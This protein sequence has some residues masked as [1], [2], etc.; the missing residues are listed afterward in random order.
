LDGYCLLAAS[1]LNELLDDLQIHSDLLRKIVTALAVLALVSGGITFLYKLAEGILARLKARQGDGQRRLRRRGAFAVFV[2][3]RVRDLDNKEEW[4]D[5]RFAELEAEVE[6]VGSSGRGRLPRPSRRGLR[7]ERSLSRA[8]IQGKEQLVLL[9]GDPGSGKSVALRFVAR[10]MAARATKSKRLDAVIPLY[11]NLK[12]LQPGGRPIDAQLIEEF[13][14]DSLRDGA[15]A[16]VDRFLEEEF[17]NGK[18]NGTWFFLFDSFDEIP[19]L[20]SSTDV[21]SAVRAYSEA[22]STFVYGVSKCRGV[23]ASRHFR[24]P[25]NY[26]LPTFTIVPLSERRRRKLIEK[27]DLDPP[28]AALV[29]DFPTGDA[30]LAALSENPLFLGL[31]IEYVRE[32]HDLPTGW[33]DVFEAFVS[34]RIDAHR[35]R[36]TNDYGIDPE[37]LRLRSEEIAFTMT[38]TG[39]LGLSP[40]RQA[41][42]DAY[43][44]AGFEHSDQLDAA[45]D[46]LQWTKLARSE[47]GNASATNPSFTFAHRRFQE[48]FATRVVLREPDRITSARLLTDA[49]WRETAV[50]LCIAQPESSGPILEEAERLLNMATSADRETTE[51]FRWQP[52]ALHVL[53]LL[54]SAFAGTSESLPA[55]LRQKVSGLLGAAVKGGTITDRKWALEVAGTA[56]P[57]DMA[58]LLLEAFRGKSPWLR[59]VAY[60]QAARLP[61]IPEEIAVEIRRALIYLGS[62]GRISRDWG[63]TKAQVMRLHP[64]APFLNTARALRLAPAIDLLV[65]VAGALAGLALTDQ[66]MGSV[67]GW[68]LLAVLLHATYYPATMMLARGMGHGLLVKR[69]LLGDVTLLAILDFIL[70]IFALEVRVAAGGLPLILS[71]TSGDSGLVVA[72]LGWTYVFNWTLAVN[73]L[74]IHRPPSSPAGWILAPLRLITPVTRRLRKLPLSSYLG[75]MLAVL[76]VG[77]VGIGMAMLPESVMLAIA[78]LG[79]AIG[80][81]TMAGLL[82]RGL[83]SEVR[84]LVEKRNWSRRHKA[85]IS[86]GEFLEFLSGFH[87]N[88]GMA[89][90]IRDVRVE[91]LLKE[92]PEAEW[93]VRDLLRH[94]RLSRENGKDPE[95]EDESAPT[96][97]SATVAS[98]AAGNGSAL[99]MVC[100]PEIEDLLGQL[101]EDLSREDEIPVA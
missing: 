70:F 88:G 42:R 51:N 48:Y 69:R 55:S 64:T 39:G 20:L 34:R 46:A 13:V 3:S 65:C 30:E 61:L 90:M 5:Q 23:I 38:A 81:V 18:I 74:S 60:R 50:T 8:L 32:H 28:E 7:R 37:E 26:G 87:D 94:V 85:Q 9:Q 72:A 16:D 77:G 12:G 44:A 11:V 1:A 45:M 95:S 27:A 73:I 14:L 6:T 41:L 4:S 10:K 21:D 40:R 96:W 91:R 59:E 71:F 66:S 31:L 29:T 86:S 33:Y 24:A 89:S 75:L 56:P 68:F 99:T 17:E 43:E 62:R 57:D 15:T 22:I 19:E 35:E 76:M 82:V 54:Q 98:W 80:V 101:L 67:L 84:N 2:E 36:L 53:G 97:D 47:E 93:M 100:N 49:N 52:G 79:V 83:I 63:A 58:A 78:Y 92:D 25:P